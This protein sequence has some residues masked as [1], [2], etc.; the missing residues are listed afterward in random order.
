MFGEVPHHRIKYIHI[1]N[2]FVISSLSIYDNICLLSYCG[3]DKT[4]HK[5]MKVEDEGKGPVKSKGIQ[6]SHM[7]IAVAFSCQKEYFE[8]PNETVS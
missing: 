1:Y 3:R 8:A 6:S 2:A 4:L 5:S 7:G